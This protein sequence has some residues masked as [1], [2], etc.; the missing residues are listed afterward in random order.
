[1]DGNRE[2]PVVPAYIA[3]KQASMPFQPPESAHTA[4]PNDLRALPGARGDTQ[5]LQTSPRW[6]VGTAWLIVLALLAAAI[7]LWRWLRGVARRTWRAYAA[8]IGAEFTPESQFPPGRVSGQMR[9]RPFLM[10]TALS[11][12]DEA[13]YFHTRAA[14]PLRNPAG[15][16][17]GLRH[18][19]LLEELQTRG[20]KPEIDLDDHEF[21]RRFFIVCNVPAD[22]PAILTPAIRRELSRYA[23]VEIYARLQEI[24]W[25]RSGAQSDRRTLQRLTEA[26]AEMADTIDALPASPRTLSERLADEALIQ[27]GV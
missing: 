5:T 22:L 4:R 6:P 26:L 11:Y 21:A 3:I 25:R 15:F 13:P 1:M 8:Q 23:D 10:E 20:E 24:E 12:E 27:K 19:S 17:L 16:I 2:R 14:L 9:G 7:G 18:K